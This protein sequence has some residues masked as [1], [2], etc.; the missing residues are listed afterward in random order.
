MCKGK[1]HRATVTEACLDYQGSITIDIELMKA[2]NILP[3]EMVHINSMATAAHWETFAIPGKK[4][5]ICL[6]GCPARIF[7]PGDEVIILSI[8]IFKEKEITGEFCHRVVHV[9]KQNN[10]I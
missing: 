4:G 8:G 5:Q 9:D 6:N 7:R 3:Y 10:I 1:I 2:A